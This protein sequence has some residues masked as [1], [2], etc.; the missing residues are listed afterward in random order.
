MGKSIDEREAGPR[1]GHGLRAQVR[2]ASW[3]EIGAMAYGERL[4]AE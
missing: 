2:G 1:A 3:E 4:R